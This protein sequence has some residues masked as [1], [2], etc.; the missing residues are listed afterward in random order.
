MYKPGIGK[1]ILMFQDQDQTMKESVKE[2]SKLQNKE[3]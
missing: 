3:E 1:K 2:Q